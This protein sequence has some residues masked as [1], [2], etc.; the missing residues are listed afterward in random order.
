[1]GKIVV[2][3]AA[4]GVAAAG[5]GWFTYKHFVSEKPARQVVVHVSKGPTI[6][7]VRELSDL[8]LLEVPIS[9]IHVSTLE[10][11][12]GGLTMAVAVRGDVQ[13]AADLGRARFEAV[14]E[15]GKSVVLV[16]PKPTAQRPRVD[17]E[18]TR[19]LEI[20]RTGMWR[21][22]GGGA[23][24]DVLTERAFADAQRVLG[25]AANDPK[26]I[27]QACGRTERVMRGFFE[28]L[29]WTVRVQW[30]TTAT[31]EAR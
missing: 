25:A 5:G 13:I 11:L 3:I 27:A 22:L 23:G 26:L 2:L 16:I 8:V 7:E 4:L 15:A 18:K 30:E 24:E 10:G 19:V 1:M 28:A 20:R 9:D 31:A 14:D 29:G 6:E 21:V 12:T 17:H